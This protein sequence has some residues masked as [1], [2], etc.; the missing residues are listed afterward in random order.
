MTD[1]GD[2][3]F[4]CTIIMDVKNSVINSKSVK[5]FYSKKQERTK[6]LQ[7]SNISS[8]DSGPKDCYV[9]LQHVNITKEKE[10]QLKTHA[11]KRKYGNLVNEKSKYQ[12]CSNQETNIFLIDKGVV[13][14]SSQ[15]SNESVSSGDCSLNKASICTENR[16][17]TCEKNTKNIYYHDNT[18]WTTSLYKTNKSN[19]TKEKVDKIDTLNSSK[20]STNLLFDDDYKSILDKVELS[21]NVSFFDDLTMNQIKKLKEDNLQYDDNEELLLNDNSPTDIKN[22]LLLSNIQNKKHVLGK[23]KLL[24]VSPKHETKSSKSLLTPKKRDAKNKKGV[25][26]PSTPKQLSN[27]LSRENKENTIKTALHTPPSK[28]DVTAKCNPMISIVKLSSSTPID[29]SDDQ[30]VPTS[31][32]PITPQRATVSCSPERSSDREL[33]EDPLCDKDKLDSSFDLSFSSTINTSIEEGDDIDQVKCKKKLKKQS[34]MDY[35]K[36]VESKKIKSVD[37]LKDAELIII[38]KKKDRPSKRLTFFTYPQGCIFC[39]N[40]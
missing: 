20:E 14:E 31:A 19:R 1:W 21:K 40:E 2:C 37:R 34:I 22:V 24:S 10:K 6:L 38:E 29:N 17:D 9:K 5:S 39:K 13:K 33:S 26:S 28:N 32:L 18:F 3:C 27:S 8:I 7:K 11:G 4:C 23:D 12:V 16:V 25:R 36:V 35:F 15:C 30:K